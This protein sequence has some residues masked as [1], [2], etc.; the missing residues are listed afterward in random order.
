MRHYLLRTILTALFM[1]AA[2][3]GVS[4]VLRGTCWQLLVWSSLP[5]GCIG[6]F[7]LLLLVIGRPPPGSTCLSGCLPRERREISAEAIT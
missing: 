5:F 7:R 1:S 3:G 4:D 2:R 6:W